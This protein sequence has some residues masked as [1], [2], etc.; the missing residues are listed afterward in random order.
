M[1]FRSGISG[2][3]IWALALLDVM[4]EALLVRLLGEFGFA[5][6]FYAIARSPPRPP[7][8]PVAKVLGSFLLLVATDTTQAVA[9]NNSM[10]WINNDTAKPWPPNWKKRWLKIDFLGCP[11]GFGSGA[12]SGAAAATVSAGG[13][14]GGG[15]VGARE[16]SRGGLGG[17]ESTGKTNDYIKPMDKER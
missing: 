8:A 5:L 7:P 3:A 1:R 16:R 4:R 10:P 15:G 6:V 11:R 17:V 12:G 13:G 14:G 2:R 9:V